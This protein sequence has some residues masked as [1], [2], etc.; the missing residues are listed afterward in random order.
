MFDKL[1]RLEEE[2]HFIEM[3]LN[4]GNLQSADPGRYTE[5]VKRHSFLKPIVSKIVEHRKLTAELGQIV[6]IL[7]GSDRELTLLA[8]EEKDVVEKKLKLLE[9]ELQRELTPKDPYADRSIYLEVR[10]G[11]GGDEAGLFAADLVR[12][13]MRYAQ[14][15]NWSAELV[16]SNSTGLK[17]LKQGVLYISGADVFP[18]LK[19]E[20]GVHRVQRVPLTEAAGRIHTSTCT[21]AIMPEVKEVEVEIDLKDLKFDTFRSGGK[22]GQN[23]NKVETAVRITH[24]PTGIIVRCQEERSQLRNRQRAMQ[25]LRAKLADQALQEQAQDITTSRRKQVGTGNR[26]EKIRTYNFPQQ[27]VTDHRVGRSWHNFEEILDGNLSS[28]S[29]ALIEWEQRQSAES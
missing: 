19:H 27:R 16:E 29:Q 25:L 23:V 7:R 21:V 6:E 22:G 17:G 14:I 13:Y 24:I 1:K 12:I 20:G 3:E 11:A 10:A 28:I 15:R 18:V 5:R 9:S 26:S 2:F 8:Q 4:R